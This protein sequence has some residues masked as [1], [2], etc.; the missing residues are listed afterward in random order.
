MFDEKFRVFPIVW[1][2]LNLLG[3]EG[4]SIC[5]RMSI[6][7]LTGSLPLVH[8]GLFCKYPKISEFRRKTADVM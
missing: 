2:I 8:N 3:V 1:E 6:Q 7:R 5:F 4:Q